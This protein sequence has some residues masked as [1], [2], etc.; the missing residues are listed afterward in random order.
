MSFHSKNKLIFIDSLNVLSSLVD[1]LV[2]NVDKDNFKD[3]S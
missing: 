1:N 2:K 3:L